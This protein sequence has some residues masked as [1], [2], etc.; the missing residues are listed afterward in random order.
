MMKGYDRGKRE[1]QINTDVERGRL[2]ELYRLKQME[3]IDR[4]NSGRRKRAEKIVR[5]LE[6]DRKK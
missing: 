2:V 4:R 6:E 3:D 5:F 1:G